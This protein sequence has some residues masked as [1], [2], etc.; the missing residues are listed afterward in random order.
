MNVNPGRVV[1]NLEWVERGYL[2]QKWW[3]S[4]V[5]KSADQRRVARGMVKLARQNPG[6]IHLRVTIHSLPI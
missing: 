3:E 6:V 4:A 2:R 1:I 5:A